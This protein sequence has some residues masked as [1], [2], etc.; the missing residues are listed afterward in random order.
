MGAVWSEICKV[1]KDLVH[2]DFEDDL[3]ICNGRGP[4]PTVLSESLM[5]LHTLTRRARYPGR[6]NHGAD[7]QAQ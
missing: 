4:I 5:E 2:K 7:R 6:A 3:L 1:D